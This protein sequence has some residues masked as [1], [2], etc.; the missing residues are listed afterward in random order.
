MSNMHLAD[1]KT[2]SVVVSLT[3]ASV[4]LREALTIQQTKKIIDMAAAAEI[5]AKRQ[6]LGAEVSDQALSIK[7][8]ALRK[9]G[10]MLKAAPKAKGVKGQFTG[11]T[12]S[13]PP[14][15]TAPTLAELGLDKKTSAVAQ[16]LATLSDEAFSEVQAGNITIAKAI[17]AVK[18][19]R[20]PT[21]DQPKAEPAPAPA[22]APA[23]DFGPS[24]EEIAASAREQQEE[25]EALRKIA[26]ADDK[27]AAALEEAKQLRA[28][29]RVLTER[30][31][32]LMNEKAELVRRI[33]SLQRKV[34]RMEQPA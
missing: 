19:E 20:S 15:E 4:A 11:G 31:N 21:T 23:E 24:A 16:K 13:E 29:N 5:Y 9:L 18:A 33:K 14:A 6:Q 3:R 30:N 25:I 8:E 28:M 34:D 26:A 32:G 12:K 2:D 27:L 1:V 17:E 10:E 22:P 7:V